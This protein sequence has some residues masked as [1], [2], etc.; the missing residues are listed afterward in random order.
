MLAAFTIAW[1][2]VEAI[3]AL[4]SGL[5][6]GSVSLIGFGFDSLIEVTSGVAVL[7]R[8]NMDA[9]AARREATEKRSLRVVG[10]SFFGLAI[11]VTADAVYSLLARDTPDPSLSGIAITAISAVLMPLLSRA[12][13]RVGRE[14]GSRTVLADSRQTDFCAY[15]SWIVLA[16]LLLHTFADIWWTDAV[17]ALL[18]VPFMAREGIQA[19]KGESCDCD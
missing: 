7:W 1:N 12:K 2:L 8:M 19:F 14:L 5:V 3:V 15:L 17:A 10:V 6:A 9:D 4:L 16:G 11:Y 13:R 18:L